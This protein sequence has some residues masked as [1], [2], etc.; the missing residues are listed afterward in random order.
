MAQHNDFGDWGEEVAAQYLAQNGF[1]ILARNFR[2]YKAEVDII[3]RT[4][5]SLVV[6]EV[7]TRTN[8]A[9]G[10][11]EDYVSDKK[12]ALL[13]E[14]AW[15]YAESIG[16]DGPIRFDIISIVG[17]PQVAAEIHH[18]E[19]AFFPMGEGDEFS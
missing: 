13:S 7:K 3:A 18:I 12:Q 1:D 8:T 6:V 14:A 10:R 2:Y 4:T 17:S 15:A 11:P 9:F 19:D 5:S 16:W